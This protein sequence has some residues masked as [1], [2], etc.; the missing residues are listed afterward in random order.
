MASFRA[1][2]ESDESLKRRKI[3]PDLLCEEDKRSLKW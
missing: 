1:E 2:G 3:D